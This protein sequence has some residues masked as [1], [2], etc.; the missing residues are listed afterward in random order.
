M[1]PPRGRMRFH[2]VRNNGGVDLTV[3]AD[4]RTLAVLRLSASELEE[5]VRTID[6]ALGNGPDEEDNRPAD[7]EE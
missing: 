2:A 7:G 6:E 4:G 3:I 1:A 5:L